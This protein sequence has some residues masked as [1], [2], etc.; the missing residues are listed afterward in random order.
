MEPPPP[1]PIHELDI[2]DKWDVKADYEV[3]E[4]EK[5]DRCE[6][7]THSFTLK[8]REIKYPLNPFKY[9][10][11]IMNPEYIPGGSLV[12]ELSVCTDCGLEKVIKYTE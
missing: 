12:G 8:K 11:A 3:P 9:I 4:I 2:L 10:K 7:N 5:T 6:P 1:E